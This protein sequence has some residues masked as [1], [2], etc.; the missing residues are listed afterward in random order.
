MAFWVENQS[1]QTSTSLI[2]YVLSRHDTTSCCAVRLNINI[3]LNKQPKLL[4][5]WEDGL[6]LM[7]FLTEVDFFQTHKWIWNKIRDRRNSSVDLAHSLIEKSSNTEKALLMLVCWRF[8]HHGWCLNKDS[9]KLNKDGIIVTCSW[10]GTLVLGD[11]LCETWFLAMC[12]NFEI[13]GG[14]FHT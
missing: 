7:L 5:S 14:F 13:P 1:I 6:L 4:I 3:G 11:M 8:C 12:H 10:I 9:Q 2:F